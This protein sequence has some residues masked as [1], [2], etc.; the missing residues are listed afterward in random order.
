MRPTTTPHMLGRTLVRVT[1]AAALV[2][3]GATWGLAS[4][5]GQYLDDMRPQP[6]ETGT[7]EPHSSDAEVD[8]AT[9]TDS[10]GSSMHDAL[11]Q[12]VWPHDDLVADG[13]DDATQQVWQDRDWSLWTQW[14]GLPE[15]AA[16]A[17]DRIHE[18]PC[19]A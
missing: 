4:C 16:T 1:A 13:M 5:E 9:A 6:A 11:S 2:A 19:E 7:W 18:G 17:Y 8:P 12:H 14:G 10:A 15:R 3:A